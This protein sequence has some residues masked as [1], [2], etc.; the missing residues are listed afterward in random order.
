MRRLLDF[1]RPHPPRPRAGRRPRASPTRPPRSCGRSCERRRDP[2]GRD[3][4]P[5]AASRSPIGASLGQAL[6][7]LLLNA[8][9]VTEDGG[10]VRMRACSAR[11]A[12]SASRSR[13]TAPASRRRSATASSTLLLDEARGG[14]DRPRAV[15]HAHHRGRARRRARLRVPRARR[16]GRHP[17]AAR[18]RRAAAAPRGLSLSPARPSSARRARREAAPTGSCARCRAAPRP[19]RGAR[20]SG[21]APAGCTRR[22]NCS[23]RLAERRAARLRGARRTRGVRPA[24]RRQSG[25]RCSRRI[26]PPRARAT[27]RSRACSSS[28]TLPG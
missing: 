2:R 17:L 28:R 16:H 22:S 9:Y 8:G 24:A 12:A 20:R 21:R 26:G 4:R 7:N 15:G 10:E 13:T 18:R 23:H 25:G 19:A 27:A 11:R 5:P 3:G 1:G 14:G 6:V